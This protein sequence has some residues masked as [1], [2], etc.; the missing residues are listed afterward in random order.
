MKYDIDKNEYSFDI[1]IFVFDWKYLVVIIGLIYYFKELEKKYE[2][3]KIIIDEIIDSYLLYN[4]EDINEENYLDFIEK[5][6]LKYLED[7][8]VYKK[9]EN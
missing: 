2:I 9:L 6:Y 8:L 5:F 3:K 4:K 7:I 1:V